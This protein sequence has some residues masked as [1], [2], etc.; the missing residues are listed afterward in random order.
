MNSHDFFGCGG[1]LCFATRGACS[2]HH[3]AKTTDDTCYRRGTCVYKTFRCMRAHKYAWHMQACA[4]T[5]THTQIYVY[6]CVYIHTHTHA[7]AGMCMWTTHVH[8]DQHAVLLC[9]PV[10]FVSVCACE[11]CALLVVWVLYVM[12]ISW[13]FVRG[14]T[15]N[16]NKKSHQ[17][18]ETCLSRLVSAQPSEISAKSV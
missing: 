4:H 15:G 1:N 18:L 17:S 11:G 6:T 5:Y 12:P 14:P 2:I 3:E 10:F 16:G 8:K 13:K 7:H 9:F